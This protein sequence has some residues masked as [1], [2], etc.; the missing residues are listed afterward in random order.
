MLEATMLLLSQ[1]I[2]AEDTDNM[3]IQERRRN[4]VLD[5][6]RTNPLKSEEFFQ[7]NMHLY[8]IRRMLRSMELFQLF[9]HAA[10]FRE[11]LENHASHTKF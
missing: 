3:M 8:I 10:S 5:M 1:T 4:K 6:V 7:N 9:E 2:Y 11:Y